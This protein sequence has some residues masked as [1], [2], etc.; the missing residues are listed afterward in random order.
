MVFPWSSGFRSSPPGHIERERKRE[1][2]RMD[3]DGKM[4]GS[5]TSFQTVL[6]S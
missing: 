6:Q 2:V 4:D 5:L 3:L 1:N